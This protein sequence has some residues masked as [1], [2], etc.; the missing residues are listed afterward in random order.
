MS[1]T[2]N[3]K[4]AIL[5][6]I[7]GAY[8]TAPGMSREQEYAAV[9][10]EYVRKG[11]LDRQQRIDLLE[12]R[13]REYDAGVYRTTAPELRETVARALTERKVYNMA[14]AR[15]TPAEWLPV[16]FR[17]TPSEEAAPGELDHMHGL[18][19][20]CTVAIVESG[21]I[22]LQ[23][24]AAQGPRKLSLV[25]DYHCCIVFADQIVE[26]VPEAFARLESTK[27]LPTTFISGPS[28]TA[29]I[30]MTRIKGVHGP[31][32]LDVIFVL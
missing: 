22:V 14:I 2:T 11:Q 19:S 25:P 30:E 6:R 16:N 24:A 10:R 26:T 7:R 5:A 27:T 13:L 20:G 9:P 15:E 18:L 31:R 23:N 4:E 21:T 17:F 8:K 29:D 12:E 3:A 32:H 28:A 1:A